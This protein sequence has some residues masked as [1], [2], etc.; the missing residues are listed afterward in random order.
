MFVF[1]DT[2]IKLFNTF[3][4]RQQSMQIII[5]VGIPIREAMRLLEKL[6]STT[7]YD[8]LVRAYIATN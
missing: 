3:I 8:E 7:I 2:S 4:Q 6:P 1:I 5:Q